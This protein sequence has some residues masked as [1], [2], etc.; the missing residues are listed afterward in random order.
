MFRTHTWLSGAWVD[1]LLSGQFLLT[2]PD[3][4]NKHMVEAEKK[5]AEGPVRATSGEGKGEEKL[6]GQ[7]S[8]NE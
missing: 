3:I 7:K 2:T 8:A 1:P 5:E 6:Q 4:T